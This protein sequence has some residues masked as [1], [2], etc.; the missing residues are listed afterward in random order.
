MS[1]MLNQSIAVLV[2]LMLI[3]GSP[4]VNANSQ[5]EKSEVTLTR[6]PFGKT[7]DG[8]E[9][10]LFT[11]TNS[12]DVQIRI[13]TYGGI[14]THIITPDKNGK[15]D[16]IT[17]GFDS[18][19][20]YLQGHPNFGAL[21]GRYANRIA[22]GKFTLDGQEYSLPINNGPNSL[23]GGLKGFD[24]KVWKAKQVEQKGL[25]ALEL[26]YISKDMEEGFPGTLTNRV[27]YSLSPDNEL[28]IEYFSHT[29]KATPINLTNHAYFNLNGHQKDQDVLNH[30]LLLNADRFTPAD[31]TLIPIGEL[32]DV[33][34]TP[35]DFT[36]P[37]AIGERIDSDDEQIAI[38]GGY[39]HNFVLNKVDDEL[40]F[41]GQ[42]YEPV[43]GRVLEFYTTQPGVQLYTGNFLNGKVIGKNNRAYNRRYGFCLETQHFPDSPNQPDFP[44]T[45][46]RP[47]EEYHHVTI[48]KF[49][50]K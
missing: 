11:F 18:L 31:K 41:G 36:T 19:E 25:P 29:D 10:D 20:R 3:G 13:M 7:Q 49:Y 4:M 46:L 12:N 39:D 33:E 21:V 1:A 14:I 45:I 9:V 2:L 24:K 16:D 44:S 43:S 30:V 28:T 34:G 38:A 5:D 37:V 27:I 22:G 32:R 48:Y 15:P 50:T 47:G 8:E 26:T 35:L 42:V 23:H 6:E 17:L 40:S